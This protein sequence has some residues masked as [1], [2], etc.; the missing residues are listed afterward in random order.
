MSFQNKVEN[1]LTLLFDLKKNYKY[2][3]IKIRNR[4]H[5][6]YPYN[7]NDFTTSV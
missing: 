5:F 7:Q 3:E 1:E 6:F 2:K 4:L